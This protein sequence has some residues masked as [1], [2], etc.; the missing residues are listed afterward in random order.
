MTA[1]TYRQRVKANAALSLIALHGYNPRPVQANAKAHIARGLPEALAY[2]KAFE[3]FADSK[4]GIRQPLETAFALIKHS[5]DA[6]VSKYDAALNHYNATGDDSQ[7]E[8]LTPMIVADS[9]AL[10]I[11]N[12]D[13]AENDPNEWDLS[14][15]L[16]IDEA[17]IAAEPYVPEAE[18]RAPAEAA[19]PQ[20]SQFQFANAINPAQQAPQPAQRPAAPQAPAYD[21]T[22]GQRT[23]TGYRPGMTG[24]KA[25]QWHGTPMGD[26]AYIRTPTG[27]RPAPTGEQARREHGTPMAPDA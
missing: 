22:Q 27:Y 21:P 8:A 16:G 17:A 11:K 15:A 6:T 23:A 5:D 13:I 4:P 20:T 12:G 1:L 24:E 9:K 10:A 26:Q 7:L 14:I 3:A 19:Q 2:Q 18:T 25:R